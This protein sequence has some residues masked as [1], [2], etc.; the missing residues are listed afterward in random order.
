MRTLWLIAALVVGF[1]GAN[2]ALASDLPPQIEADKGFM[3]C[4]ASLADMVK[5][6][7][8]YKRIPLDTEE[9]ANAFVVQLHKLYIG[10]STDVAFYAWMSMNYPGHDYEQVVISE[11]VRR[12]KR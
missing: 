6:D 11:H 7:K 4:Y 3:T 12:C 8:R 9:Q 2:V 10:Q 1:S 5:A